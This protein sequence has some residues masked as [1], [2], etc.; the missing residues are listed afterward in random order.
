LFWGYKVKIPLFTLFCAGSL[1]VSSFGKNSILSV[2][3][4]GTA[5]GIIAP[6]SHDSSQVVEQS[7]Y[8]HS[9]SQRSQKLLEQAIALG[10][11]SKTLSENEECAKSEEGKEKVKEIKRMI[12]DIK[13][14][15]KKIVEEMA[16]SCKAR[17]VEM[18]K[19]IHKL[20]K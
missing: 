14:E 2:E 20:K 10:E 11:L 3:S 15:R 9:F 4:V 8:E 13:R 16:K 17:K 5:D 12:A 19:K 6:E 7:E 18:Q 1:F